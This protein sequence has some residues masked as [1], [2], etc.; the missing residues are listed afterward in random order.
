[1]KDA[2]SELTILVRDYAQGRLPFW[3][4]HHSFIEG[5]VR[6]PERAMGWARWNRVYQ[7]VLISAPD[8]VSEADQAS[9]VIGESTLKARLAELTVGHR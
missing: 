2:T 4:F 9:G 1:M 8:P 5:F 7:L 6:L 3:A